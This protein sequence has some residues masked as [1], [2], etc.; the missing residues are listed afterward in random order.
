MFCIDWNESEPIEIEGNETDGDYTRL[1]FVITPCNYIHT[2]LG[3]QGDFVSP[4]C[5][6]DLQE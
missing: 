1:E 2:M 6:G 4:E 5:I 3:S